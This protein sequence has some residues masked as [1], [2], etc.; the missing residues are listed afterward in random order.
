MTCYVM[1]MSQFT[2]RMPVL[3]SPEQRARLERIAAR[4][5]RSI[6]AVIRAAIDAYTA[7]RQRS[8]REALDELYALNAPVADWP[9]L[10]A[11][12]I[13]GALGEGADQVRER[14]RR[15]GRGGE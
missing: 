5:E 6:G 10:K 3:L 4:E 1:R 13:A 14:L 8:R 7:P 15:D 9:S 12:I 2:N 11:E